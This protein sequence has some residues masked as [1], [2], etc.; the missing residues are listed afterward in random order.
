[1]GD[2]LR[3]SNDLPGS[4]EN[5][6]S[7]ELPTASERLRFQRFQRFQG[8]FPSPHSSDEEDTILRGARTWQRR[9]RHYSPD[10]DG[11]EPSRSGIP[12]SPDL[13]V[14]ARTVREVLDA[15]LQGVLRGEARLGVGNGPTAAPPPYDRLIRAGESSAPGHSLRLLTLELHSID[16]RE[17]ILEIERQ[18]SDTRGE[19]QAFRGF[20]RR[21]AR[22]I[23]DIESSLALVRR[24]ME[25][26]NTR[27]GSID[28]Q[29]AQLAS[30]AATP[31]HV[32]E[33]NWSTTFAI[34]F[35]SCLISLL[36]SYISID[37]LAALIAH[38]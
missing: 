10:G 2:S 37:F 16:I 18:V 29:F 33:V 7:S 13:S 12:N 3:H 22:S 11:A 31:V 23:D 38:K 30:S 15:P 24:D 36:A 35:V 5:P 32:G 28:T 26:A 27:S 4:S 8:R 34:A 19:L 14:Q 17:R 21:A 1:M 6:P 9:M 20:E 25:A